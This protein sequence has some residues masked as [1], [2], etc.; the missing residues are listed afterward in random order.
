MGAEMG[1]EM[2]AEMV[3][4]VGRLARKM[5][6]RDGEDRSAFEAAAAAAS[7]L[8]VDSVLERISVFRALDHADL[9]RAVD[10]CDALAA[11]GH[12]K[13][14]VVDSAAAHLRTLDV[15]A[16]CRAR[17]LGRLALDGAPKQKKGCFLRRDSALKRLERLS[18]S[19]ARNAHMCPPTRP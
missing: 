6:P 8:T 14:L 19:V 10:A 4:H 9:F 1:A 3:K 17:L 11:S 15:D 16:G 12:C 18:A 5:R 7:G 2:A 13:L